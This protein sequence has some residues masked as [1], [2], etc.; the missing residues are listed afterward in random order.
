MPEGD[1]AQHGLAA[2]QNVQDA[3]ASGPVD[4][5]TGFDPPNA[6]TRASMMI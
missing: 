5:L 3:T 2:H 1:L 6:L 4:E